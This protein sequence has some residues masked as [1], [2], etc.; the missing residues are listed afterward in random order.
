MASTSTWHNVKLPDLPQAD[1]ILPETAALDAFKLAAAQYVARSLE[2]P[3]DKALE[4]IESGR[5]GKSMSADFQVAV[6]RFRLKGDP[7]AFAKKI[8]DEVRS[9]MSSSTGS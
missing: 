9:L 8:A 2:L 1:G 6:P 7:K 4:G 5:T 3:L